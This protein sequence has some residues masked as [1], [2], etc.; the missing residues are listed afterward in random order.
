MLLFVGR[1]VVAVT[2]RPGYR[3]TNVLK[4]PVRPLASAF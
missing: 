4:W 3:M 1:D 2:V